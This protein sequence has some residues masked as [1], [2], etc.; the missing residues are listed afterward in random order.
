MKIRT[1]LPIFLIIFCALLFVFK[2]ELKTYYFSIKFP[3]PVIFHNVSV[4]FQ[5]GMI[6][7]MGENS[8]V[9]FNWKEPKTY[10]YVAKMDISDKDKVNKLH[11]LKTK[12]FKI[13]EVKDILFKEH[14][15]F[16][17]SYIDRTSNYNKAIY[18]IPMNIQITFV[19]AKENY[20]KF[21]YIIDEI[22]FTG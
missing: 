8:I 21:K 9:I 1:L 18:V 7:D 10:L 13:L 20:S 22:E 5:K 15:S 6:Y 19:G 17:I 11:F 2:S 12:N 14:E 4:S 16:T 3:S